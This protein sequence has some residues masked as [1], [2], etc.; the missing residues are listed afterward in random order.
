MAPTRCVLEWLIFGGATS[1]VMACNQGLVP[2]DE[3]EAEREPA[4]A[5]AEAMPGQPAREIE[6]GRF[7]GGYIAET[8]EFYFRQVPRELP[9][10]V[11]RGDLRSAGQAS[12]ATGSWCEANTISDG[13]SGSNP[14]DSFEIYSVDS[15]VSFSPSACQS[16][17]TGALTAGDL[18]A[19]TAFDATDFFGGVFCFDTVVTNFYDT[20]TWPGVIAEIT[21]F[22]GATSE[23]PYRYPIGTTAPTV[24]DDTVDETIATW[25]YGSL[26][27][28]QAQH[29]PWA[30]KF[31][32]NDFAFEG[33][34]I[35]Q[36]YENCGNAFDDDC[37]GD[38][39]GLDVDCHFGP[40]VCA[41][42]ADCATN[43]CVAGTCA[44]DCRDGFFGPT[45][46]WPCMGG[47]GCGAG[48]CDDGRLGT[49]TCDCGANATGELCGTCAD[50]YY[51]AGCTAC[52]GGGGVAQCS[53]HGTCNDGNSGTGACVCAAGFA[54]ADCS[55]CA[56]GRFGASCAPCPGGESNPCSGNG[57]CAE[58]IAGSGTC[59]CDSG[60]SGADCS[61]PA[62]VLTAPT[63][64][65]ASDNPSSPSG[66]PVV[67]ITWNPVAGATY[68]DVYRDGVLLVSH[69]ALTAASDTDPPGGLDASTASVTAT[70]ATDSTFVNLTLTGLRTVYGPSTAASYTVTACADSVCSPPSLPDTGYPFVYNTVISGPTDVQ[71]QRTGADA[72]SSFFTNLDGAT[73]SPWSDR[74]APADGSARWY[75]AVVPRPN[76]QTPLVVGPDRG[77]RAG[78]MIDAGL[79][80]AC[81]AGRGTAHCWGDNAVGQSGNGTTGSTLTETTVVGLTGVRSVA[82]GRNHRCALRFDGTVSCWGANDRFQLGDP[83]ST[84]A[85]TPQP[86]VGLTGVDALVAG[87]SHTCALNVDGTVVCWGANNLNQL[88]DGTS[89]DSATPNPVGS[90]SGVVAIAAR[91]DHT[92]ALK[93]DRSVWCW[94][95]NVYSQLGDGS[96]APTAV[97]V[98]AAGVTDAVG[99]SVG[100]RHSCALRPNGTVV[101]WGDN[102][103]GQVGD[104][105]TTLRTVP[106][107]V[108]GLD[109][110]TSLSLGLIHSCALRSG[111]D[112][113]CW[114]ANGNGQLGDGTVQPYR[115]GAAPASA[116]PGPVAGLA[117]SGQ[118]NCAIGHEGTLSCWGQN[119]WG[120]LG[121]GTTVASA[122]ARTWSPAYAVL[123]RIA[124]VAASAASTCALDSF[125]RVRC[126]GANGA[127]Q[128]GRNDAVTIGDDEVAG[129]ST[130][131]TVLLGGVATSIHAA[132][133]GNTFCAILSN[134]TARCWGGDGFD[135]PLGDDEEVSTG[136]LLTGG[137]VASPIIDIDLDLSAVST[138]RCITYGGGEVACNSMVVVG[139]GGGGG[140]D[141]SIAYDSTAGVYEACTINGSAGGVYC[142]KPSGGDPRGALG[143]GGAAV[144]QFPAL[145][146]Q[147]GGVGG[148]R[149]AFDVVHSRYATLTLDHGFSVRGFGQNALGV[150]GAGGPTTI[151]DDEPANGN[152]VDV[153]AGA[154]ANGGFVNI[155]LSDRTACA[156]TRPNFMFGGRDLYCW[157]RNTWGQLGFANTTTLG[158]DELASAWGPSL[159]ADIATTFAV[160][161]DHVCVVTGTGMGVRCWGRGSSGQLGNGSTA[162]IGD[163]EPASASTTLT[164]FY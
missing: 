147:V 150:L 98:Q 48:T 66:P 16:L 70:D 149:G 115:A 88:G 63:G 163:N 83:L 81:Y 155:E 104:G 90:L 30:F 121:D 117:S 51:G 87:I 54:G 32:G 133:A 31:G 130:L 5:V 96:T 89:L 92:C 94:G 138:S 2:P 144:A 142:F 67:N 56:P 10:G 85:L 35:A 93:G 1:I 109:R 72:S 9:D 80:G 44:P 137:S 76:G 45:C 160:G 41:V 6:V 101:C 128:L 145:A 97:P 110:V 108:A 143:S 62:G 46:T 159:S 127:G 53:G 37:D 114:G 18:P 23:Q 146:P 68:Y 61:T 152:Q 24:A 156:V 12:V 129:P 123:G 148:V 107:P 59:T 27:P 43:N 82:A 64:V 116:V 38:V 52:P 57:V 17:V 157:G 95:T 91:A 26:A 13:T 153:L 71:W 28:G 151:G 126:W 11:V 75:R 112:V 19:R 99:I 134:G 3:D 84:G 132:P 74:T 21:L 25:Y 40:Y 161:A 111:G 50:G 140:V 154:W 125:G 105:T 119:T 79:T 7:E 39:D 22:D 164:L 55:G 124:E 15:S 42:D 86:V 158:D 60:F 122:T 118:F 49:G 100:L 69:V 33:R 78:Y 34:L 4:R 29:V 106:T 135:T 162:T 20:E 131:R 73:G 8:G 14:V 141:V 103:Y 58:G 120:Q 36:V 139:T 102:T 47:L 136:P 77:S 65:S 113:W